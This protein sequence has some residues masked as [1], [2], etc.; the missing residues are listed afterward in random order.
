MT[1]NEEILLPLPTRYE[2]IILHY[3]Q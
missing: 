1:E 2:T 3:N